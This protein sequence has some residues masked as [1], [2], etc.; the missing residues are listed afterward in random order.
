MERSCCHCRKRGCGLERQAGR[1]PH[2]L[3]TGNHQSAG[4][5]TEEAA[6][7]NVI[8]LRV[9]RTF[10]GCL[11]HAC[12][13]KS[14]HNWP[15]HILQGGL[16]QAPADVYIRIVYAEGLVADDNAPGRQG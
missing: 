2:Q 3:P 13:V 7:K 14:W 1:Y 4:I 12:D 16:I 15:A 11:H 10:R 9:A 5:A 6:A 8:T